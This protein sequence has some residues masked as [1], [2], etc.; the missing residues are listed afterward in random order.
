MAIQEKSKHITAEKINVI[1]FQS[2][3]A[4]QEIKFLKQASWQSSEKNE[5]S[6]MT[7]GACHPQKG[8]GDEKLA[9]VL[10]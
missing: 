1:A 3:A 5:E 2:Y 7:S 8:N 6:H 4:R 10:F 9:F